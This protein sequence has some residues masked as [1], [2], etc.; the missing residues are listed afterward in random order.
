[1][2]EAGDRIDIAGI[3]TSLPT[4]FMK[5]TTQLVLLFIATSGLLQADWPQ[6][7]GTQRTGISSETG[8]LRSFPADGPRILWETDLEKGFGGCA[9]VGDEV[10]VVDRVMKEKDILLCFDATNGKEKWRYESPSEGEPSFPGSRSVPTVREDAV[11]FIG[12]FGEVHCVD[13]Q[14]HTARWK[15]KM[16]D[17]YPESKTPR[18]GYAQCALVTGDL[19]FVTPFGS[20]VGIA[21]WDRK[22]GKELWRSGPIGDSHASPTLLEIGGEQ[23][24]VL[25]S[26][27]N[28][29]ERKGLVTSYRPRDGKVLWQTDHYY[30]KIPIPIVTKVSEELL[31]VTGGYDCGSKMLSIVKNGELYKVSE[32][33]G[34]K[35]GSQIHPP[36]V[37]DNHLYFL[38]NENSNHR[39]AARRATG[40]LSCWDLEGK[41][42]WRTGDKPFMGRGGSIYADGM[43]I[44]QDGEK[45]VLRLGEASPG[46]FKLLAE[47]NVFGSDLSK[48]F[49]LKFWSPMALS[50]GRLYMRG[51]NRLLCVDLKK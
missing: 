16:A 21:G 20:K 31:F 7:Q 23:H 11:Y 43:L 9:V 37:I 41:E 45:G 44:I 49:D 36:F 15:I 10:F 4:I 30:N 24:I 2:T 28:Q 5:A 8:L 3:L 32:K 14:T 6:F 48:K 29:G 38:A 33:W 17:R 12:S 35:K 39:V 25:I 13:R 26:V 19:V 42:L 22:S 50:E 34:I 46:G 40:G 47:A 1:M 51:Q 18:W 27:I